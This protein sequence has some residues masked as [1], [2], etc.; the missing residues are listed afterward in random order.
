MNN[1]AAGLLHRDH[2]LATIGADCRAGPNA[3][4]LLAVLEVEAGK[5]EQ[6]KMCVLPRSSSNTHARSTTR[7]YEAIPNM[8]PRTWGLTVQSSCSRF[9]CW[10]RRRAAAKRRAM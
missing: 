1:A 5:S 3:A 8:S 2:L 10:P 6:S 9:P 4:V 7:S